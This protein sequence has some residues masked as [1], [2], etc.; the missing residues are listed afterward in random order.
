MSSMTGCHILM[1]TDALGGVWQYSTGLAAELARGGCSVSLAVMGPEPDA[2]QRGCI[3]GVEGVRVIGTGLPLDWMCA[4]HAEVTAAATEL[5]S[6]VRECGATIVHCNSPAIAGAATFPMPVVA[7]AHG[8]IATWWQAA[9]PGPVEPAYRWHGEAMRRGLIAADVA[10]APTASFAATLQATYA[11]PTL[12]MVVHNGRATPQPGAPI[13]HPLDIALTV[14]RMWDPVKN[15][16]LLDKVAASINGSF[17]AAGALRGPHGE[18]TALR[19]LVALG[20]LPGPT[21]NEL[22]VRQP[23]FVSAATF[24]PFGL[25]VLEAACAGC[26]LVLSDIPTFRELWNGA[27]LFAD[28]DDAEGFAAA[29]RHL[30]GNPATRRSL[31][32]AAQARAAR[33]RPAQMASAMTTIYRRL[34][35]AREAAA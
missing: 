31:S 9:R 30:Q 7:V 26:A 21:L 28:P 10:I 23:I 32:S 8:C 3:A 4:D 19:H 5:A 33:Y 24:E 34:L 6:L 14:G 29:I 16:A 25:A 2:A 12:P 1:T 27:A 17:L 11:L 22:L 15:A 35:P 13:N 18:T 20:E